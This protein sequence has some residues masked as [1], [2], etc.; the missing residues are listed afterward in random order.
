[1]SSA[2][3]SEVL[4]PEPARVEDVLTRWAAVASGRLAIVEDHRQWTFGELQTAV[5]HATRC[6]T[7]AK[8]RSGDRVVL[9]CENSCGAVALYFACTTLGAWPVIVHASLSEREIDEVAAHSDAR[10]MIFAISTSVR[11]RTHSARCKATIHHVGGIG[12]IG[13]G[14]LNEHAVPELQ[15]DDPG[16]GVAAVIYTTGTTGCPKGVMLTHRNLLFVA[17]AT[18]D[19]RRLGPED[20]VYAVLPISHSLG[21]AGVLLGSL[22]RGAT[23]RIPPRFDPQHVVRA[24]AHEQISVMIG[25]PSMF[26]IIAQFAQR[27]GKVPILAPALRLISSAGAPLDSGTKM[28]AEAAFAL[29]LHNGY[30]ITEC[31]PS[32]TLTLIDAPPTDCSIGHLLPGVEARLTVAADE[33]SGELWVRTP[34]FMKGYYKAPDETRNVIDSERWFRTGDL[35]RRDVNG[36][37]FIIGR[38]K[39]LI[40][41]FGFNVHPAEIEAALNEHPSVFRCAVVGRASGDTEDIVAFVQL[42]DGTAATACQLSDHLAGRLAPYKRPTEI[43]I[44]AQMP[45]TVTGK[46]LKADLA[47]RLRESRAAA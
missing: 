5:Q 2:P 34:G 20:R 42:A 47:R 3:L 17:G 12:Q 30:G 43:I 7:E 10:R 39:E 40:I 23:I 9:V 44:A 26:A 14:P 25:T 13:L 18:S 29:P 46:I 45:V 28:A 32:L 4:G 33:S 36:N 21:L 8:I 19:A 24:L 27:K 15:E 41:R 38:A 22:L 1:M 16:D 37:Y 35:A 6:L 11:A 31:G